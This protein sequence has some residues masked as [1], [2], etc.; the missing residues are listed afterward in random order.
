MGILDPNLSF[1]V[2]P[3]KIAYLFFKATSFGG[4]LPRLPS[5]LVEFDCSYSLISGGLVNRNVQNLQNLVFFDVS[6]C[7]FNQKVPS[8]LGSLP[9][10]KY[11]YL[12]DSFI[13]GDLSYM[14]GMPSI[15]ENWIDVNPDFGG[16]I[17][18]FI[19][20]LT[21]LRSF[22]VTQSN[23]VGTLPEELGNLFQMETLWLYGNRLTGTIPTVYGSGMPRIK[24]FRVESNQLF[25]TIPASICSKRTNAFPGG[26]LEVLGAD[27][28]RLAVRVWL[29][30]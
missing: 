1:V 20:D 18:T 22:S 13:S 10:L 16:T 4:D 11:L 7:A 12:S 30:V 5:G 8:V 6:G 17:P 9:K 25:G 14:R 2:C 21:T 15:I 24:A 28:S 26:N 3:L 27:Y 23:L 29:F 19:G